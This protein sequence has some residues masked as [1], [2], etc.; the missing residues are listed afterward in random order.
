MYYLLQL[1]IKTYAK[2]LRNG[3]FGSKY[4]DKQPLFLCIYQT[5]RKAL[6][7]LYLPPMDGNVH[8]QVQSESVMLLLGNA[9]L[10]HC[11]V[12]NSQTC[13]WTCAE[14]SLLLFAS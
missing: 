3:V 5:V 6:Y 1:S 14:V 12:E 8:R 7:I 9:H 11:H 13:V 2:D 4:D 10:E